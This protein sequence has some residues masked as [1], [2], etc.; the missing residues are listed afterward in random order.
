MIT[1]DRLY[2]WSNS[3][4]ELPQDR[5]WA[6]AEK[7]FKQ[8]FVFSKVK[9]MDSP[10]L[11]IRSNLIMRG[12]NLLAKLRSGFEIETG[13]YTGIPWEERSCKICTLEFVEDEISFL[14]CAQCINLNTASTT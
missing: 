3:N 14:F 13:W 1:F 8:K 11:L 2:K 5:W 4:P 9:V 7:R 6:G 10:N 12:R